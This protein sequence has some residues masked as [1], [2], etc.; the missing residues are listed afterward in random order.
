[1]WW[2]VI[3]KIP[4]FY[5]E[6]IRIATGGFPAS[7][8]DGILMTGQDDRE[9]LRRET[10]ISAS[11]ETAP[12]PSCILLLIFSLF[13]LFTPI[14]ANAQLL[15]KSPL[16]IPVRV[17]GPSLVIVPVMMNR[18]GPYDFLLDTGSSVTMVDE[19]F[20]EEIGLSLS[21]RTTIVSIQGGEAT[22]FTAEA[23]IVS[24]AGAQVDQ[25]TIGVVKSFASVPVK[26]RG[27]LGEDFLRNFDL[28]LDYRHHFLQFDSNLG[29]LAE[30]LTGERVPVSLVGCDHLAT[31]SNRLIL[32]TRIRDLTHH[33]VKL[34]LDTGTNV[35]VLHGP[36]L[37]LPVTRDNSVYAAG[38]SVS[39]AIIMAGSWQR[40]GF[41][42]IGDRTSVYDPPTVVISVRRTSDVD[43]LLPASIFHS[44]FISH[45]GEF[46]ILNPVIRPTTS[47]T[48]HHGATK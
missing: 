19:K 4:A 33:Q 14:S 23:G 29:S 41:V 32:T 26:V 48:D 37:Q 39:S 8:Q 42:E 11:G 43:G 27:V 18:R 6:T 34:L 38:N 17:T 46:V 35:L 12:L 2:S 47:Q 44:I 3:A 7:G 25:L 28:L 22:M 1:M 24:V 45:S 13:S 9:A 21:G 16:R 15:H 30:M 20:A 31:I 10:N 36:Q 40:T 5:F